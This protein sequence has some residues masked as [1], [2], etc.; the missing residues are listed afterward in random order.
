MVK[1]GRATPRNISFISKTYM[2]IYLL[3][4]FHTGK[5]YTNI[6]STYQAM[7]YFHSIAGH[8]KT[9]DSEFCINKLEDIKCT[10]RYTIQKKSSISIK[11]LYKLYSHFRGKLTSRTN[12]C[13]A[14]ICDFL[15]FLCF[16]EV[17][18]VRR[19]DV[20]IRNTTLLFLLKGVKE[21]SIKKEMGLSP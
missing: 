4:L 16:S 15:G 10:I 19:N 14:R 21:S 20:V 1:L 18:N 2:V 8:P 9:C 6:C 3:K 7:N 5:P 12:L 11:H 13:A 17:I